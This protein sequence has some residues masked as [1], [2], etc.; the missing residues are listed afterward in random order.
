MQPHWTAKDLMV[1]GGKIHYVRTGDGSKPPVVL[2]HGFSDNGMC[3]L[4][5]ALAL[6]KD[7]DVILPD[8]RGHGKSARVQPGEGID[9][10]ADLAGFIRGLGLDK[11]V[12]GGHSMGGNV[13]GRLGERYPELV[14]GLILEDPA[15]FT[16]PPLPKAGEPQPPPPPRHGDW[17]LDLKKMSLEQMM[18]RCHQDNP[19]WPEIEL[20]PWAES[21]Q[22]FDLQ[23]LEAD[24][25]IRG[26]W[27][28]TAKALTCPTLLITA[29]HRKGAILTKA[30]AKLA[31]ELNDKI[32]VVYIPKAGHSIRRENFPAYMQAVTKF[33]KKVY[34]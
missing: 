12:A 27:R 3:W 24:M 15:W 18:D 17:M 28:E 19:T 20:R 25:G 6:E 30:N 29:V 11:P 31:K 1:G 33:L 21:K 32:Q 13:S 22:E 26:D 8:A 34:G 14:R 2:A 16:P 4:P 5:V 9:G 10:P 23:F 7:Y